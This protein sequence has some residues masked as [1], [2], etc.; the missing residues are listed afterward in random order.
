MKVLALQESQYRFGVGP[1]VIRAVAVRQE[2][3]FD[4][5]PWWHI[6]AEVAGGTPVH[7]GGWIRR[8]LYVEGAVFAQ[9]VRLRAEA[10]YRVTGA[11]SPGSVP[12]AG[13][14]GSA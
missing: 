7:H 13:R 9:L 14:A 4:D 10:P 2:V 5:E 6:E 12:A 11:G 1:I 3:S 8:E